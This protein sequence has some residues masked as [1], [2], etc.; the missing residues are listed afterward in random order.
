MAA[1]S[2]EWA[3][4]AKRT[5][6]GGD[7]V[8]TPTGTV[9]TALTNSGLHGSDGLKTGMGVVTPVLTERGLI[10][11]DGLATGP[12]AAAPDL[13]ERGLRGG[14][15]LDTA[16][17]PAAPAVAER[18]LSGD[19]GVNTPLG[20]VVPA[21]AKRGL[22]GL[23]GGGVNPYAFY[24]GGAGLG[25]VCGYLIAGWAGLLVWLAFG[26]HFGAQVLLSDYVQHYGLERARVG[27]KLEP[28]GE[29]H[30]WNAPH[31]F[32]SALMLNA[33]RH[34]DHHAHPT[35]PYPAL[36]LEPDSPMLPWPLPLA[37]LI[38]LSPKRWRKAMRPLVAKVGRRS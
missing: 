33:P 20:A 35:R 18:G 32:S 31:W 14:G 4:L 13:A 19:G 10:G 8:T 28:A 22:R 36:R 37:C 30:S 12:D 9:S 38:A 29:R 1:T 11:S 26:L 23:R 34:S 2:D 15:G 21:L 5:L 17:G 27:A 24:A 7:G 16:M 25:L 3:D 6:R